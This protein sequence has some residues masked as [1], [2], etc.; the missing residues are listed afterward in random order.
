MAPAG[1]EANRPHSAPVA[2]GRPKRKLTASAPVAPGGPGRSVHRP[3][4]SAAGAECGTFASG[5]AGGDS[6]RRRKSFC[7]V[8]QFARSRRAPQARS[9]FRFPGG[10]RAGIP[11]GGGIPF[12]VSVKCPRPAERGRRRAPSVCLGAG[13]AGRICFLFH[14]RAFFILFSSLLSILLSPCPLPLAT[15]LRKAGEERSNLFSILF[16]VLFSI[17]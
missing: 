9:G 7:S 15:S 12:S 6:C 2:L 4:T 16:S 3:A 13:F 10:R 5:P 1:L 8:G 17:L 11:G 14:P